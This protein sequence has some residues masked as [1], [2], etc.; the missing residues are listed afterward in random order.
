[1][2]RK[3]LL[4]ALAALLAAGAAAAGPPKEE[5]LS[6]D[7]RHSSW[8]HV[9]GTMTIK[10][11]DVK[12]GYCLE[13][14]VKGDPYF[15]EGF[16]IDGIFESV[17]RKNAAMTPHSAWYTWTSSKGW[18]TMDCLWDGSGKAGVRVVEN[19]KDN[20]NTTVPAFDQGRD[21]LDAIWWL[22]WQDYDDR[23][24]PVTV[25]VIYRERAVPTYL[26]TSM[27]VAIEVNGE[28]VP[29]VQLVLE[30]NR[31]RLITLW[32]TDD[33]LRT[34]VL[35]RV[36]VE[37]GSVEGSLQGY[38]VR[39]I[40]KDPRTVASRMQPVRKPENTGL[41]AKSLLP[42]ADPWATVSDDDEGVDTKNYSGR[43]TGK[44]TRAAEGRAKPVRQTNSTVSNI[45]SVLPPVSLLGA[46]GDSNV[47][48]SIT[49]GLDP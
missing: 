35:F 4:C 22:R 25:N 42:V 18:R 45:K 43:E 32:L 41:G 15:R 24:N 6:Y 13:A 31:E 48:I 14:S 5:R 34:P 33:A 3:I 38:K 19:G 20:V 7:L 12:E 29:C 36:A 26:R 44:G 10:G 40:R 39:E 49:N 11:K 27:K 17:F 16:N 47:N 28:M 9:F 30:R 46:D 2:V 8:D 23:T 1:M 37:G 21:I